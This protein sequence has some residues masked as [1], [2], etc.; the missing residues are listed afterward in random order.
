MVFTGTSKILATAEPGSARRL[1]FHRGLPFSP[2]GELAPGGLAGL[3]DTRIL[4]IGSYEGRSAVWLLEH[5]LTDPSARLFCIDLFSEDDY[6][7]RFD[8]NIRHTG[9]AHKVTTL[10]G[11][12]VSLLDGLEVCS[13]DAVYVDGSHRAVDVLWDAVASWRLLKEG[14]VLM[15]DDYLWER[16]RPAPDRPQA[17]VDRFLELVAGDCDVLLHD[18]QVA[19]RKRA[20]ISPAGDGE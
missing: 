10:T 3:A 5:I 18:Y 15:F 2:P 7:L 8:H 6:S 4:E 9:A 13:F 1:Q 17:A 20:T 19:I 14:G 11:R 12:S 16:E